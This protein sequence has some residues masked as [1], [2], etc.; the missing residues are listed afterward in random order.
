[1]DFNPTPF[2]LLSALLTWSQVFGT[3]VLLVLLAS[4]VGL[5]GS[6][7]TEGV[8]A[9]VQHVG[10]FCRDLFSLSPRRIAA[11]T[12]LTLREALRRKALLVFVVF[13]ILFMFAGWFLSSTNLPP[14]NQPRL[15]V[16]FVLRAIMWL[17]LP[18]VLLLSC[19]GLPEDIRLRSL[20]TVVTKP[21][22][23]VEVVLGRMLGYSVIAGLVLAVMGFVGWAWIVRQLPAEAQ[24]YLTCRK[25]IFGTLHFRDREGNERDA[26]GNLLTAGINTGDVWE[27]RSYIEGA[28]KARAIWKFEGVT[29]DLLDPRGNL[30]LESRFQAFRSYKGDLSRPLYYQYVLVNP[31]TGLR[32]PTRFREVNEFRFR[33]DEIPRKLPKVAEVATDTPSA[34]G[35]QA[36]DLIDD[37]VSPQGELVVEVSCADPNQYL[38]M[39]RPDL[40]IR[41]P[42]LPFVAGY[43]KAV[44]C[45]GMVL[46]LVIFLGVT[47]ST[48]AKGPVATLLTFC[49]I[50]VGMTARDFM[51]CLVGDEYA[52]QKVSLY[53]GGRQAAQSGGGVFESIYRVVT[54]MNPTVPLPEGPAT[55]AMKRVDQAIVGFLWL[56][57]KIIPDFEYSDRAMRYLAGGFDVDWSSAFF[58]TIMLTLAYFIPCVLLGQFALRVRELEAK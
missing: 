49:L 23:R 10:D 32:V 13:A 14:E 57:H 51:G 41:T 20:H 47:A 46:L 27:F 12:Q 45:I 29:A 15:Y 6:R 3:A 4:F 55:A 31:E 16:S 11:L 33:V 37:I 39:S 50:V 5:T 38:G 18:L 54:H 9:W 17:M 56:V 52:L 22:H 21:V 42:D 35:K 19:W 44:I 7:G 40:F 53:A 1:M 30:L 43:T 28:T 36:Y 58:P 8:L 24:P 48:F 34:D 2:D 26:K 25:P